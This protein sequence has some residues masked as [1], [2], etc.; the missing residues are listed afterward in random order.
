VSQRQRDQVPAT[1]AWLVAAIAAKHGSPIAVDHLIPIARDRLEQDTLSLGLVEPAPTFRRQDLL[2]SLQ[3]LSGSGVEV[4]APGIIAADRRRVAE[5]E[6]NY[7]SAMAEGATM[8]LGRATAALPLG[9]AVTEWDDWNFKQY[10]EELLQFTLLTARD[11][12][13]LG[14][15]ME[16]GLAASQALLDLKLD[17]LA[18]LRGVADSS[19]YLAAAARHLA[20]PTR[21][22]LSTIARAKPLHDLLGGP[23]DSQYAWWPRSPVRPRPAQQEEMARVSTFVALVPPDVDDALGQDPYVDDLPALI[24]QLGPEARSAVAHATRRHLE[25]A[26]QRA[27]EAKSRLVTSN[28]RLVIAIGRTYTGRGLDLLDVLQEGNLGLLRAAEKFNHRLGF[29]FSTYATWWIRQSITRAVA[30]DAHVVRAPVHVVEQVA[31]VRRLLRLSYDEALDTAVLPSIA[32]EYQAQFGT[33][34]DRELVAA[35]IRAFNVESLETLMEVDLDGDGIPDFHDY[36]ADRVSELP[37]SA[38][39]RRDTAETIRRVLGG[40]TS[41]EQRVVVLRYGLDDGRARTLEEVGREFGV[42]RERIRQIEAK[43]FRKLRHHTRSVI[44]KNLHADAQTYHTSYQAPPVVRA[45]SSDQPRRNPPMHRARSHATS[46]FHGKAA[47]LGDRVSVN[48]VI[49]WVC[50]TRVEGAVCTT[51]RLGFD[52]TDPDRI[53]CACSSPNLS[54]GHRYWIVGQLGEYS[55]LPSTGPYCTNCHKPFVAKRVEPQVSEGF[56]SS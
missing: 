36:L 45:L 26:V 34:L 25:R 53:A 52:K 39:T 24:T 2:T 15:A 27:F 44:L 37:L 31:R 47:Q 38:A 19:R 55:H 30:D 7:T 18:T 3:G 42:T 50:E 41:R 9:T 28:L 29:K 48:G 12:S 8:P 23:F 49:A 4:R 11:E 6:A 14:F 22:S 13:R 46:P 10:R 33:D 51:A 35:A 17:G 43:A 5:Y 32:A 54:L 20:W 1:V 56:G 40:L 16:L 21:L